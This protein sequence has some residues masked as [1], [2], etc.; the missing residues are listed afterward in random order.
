MPTGSNPDTLVVIDAQP[1]SSAGVRIAEHYSKG[2]AVLTSWHATPPEF[3]VE[4]QTSV[5]SEPTIAE[6]LRAAAQRRI[7]WVA[8]RRD[9]HA[10]A[11]CHRARRDRFRRAL[12]FDK[13]HA[14]VGRNAQTVVIT[15]S[16]N[17]IAK[18]FSGLQDRSA[19]SDFD[20]GSIDGEFWHGGLRVKTA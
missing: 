15:E 11:T 10:L 12:Y 8:V 1:S 7:A 18:H 5:A 19:R 20:F 4:H 17:L 14:A 2:A 16:R 9:F 13:A 3:A 6:A